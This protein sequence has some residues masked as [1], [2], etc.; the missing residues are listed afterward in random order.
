MNAP[1][2]L[3]F[4]AAALCILLTGCHI[5]SAPEETT[6]AAMDTV[7]SM[8]AYG[9]GAREALNRASEELSRLDRTLSVTGEKSAVSALNSAGGSWTDVGEDCAALLSAATGLSSLTDGALDVTAYP[10]VRAWGFTTGSYRIPDAEELGSLLRKIDWTALELDGTSARLPEGMA[11]DLGAVAK[12]YACDRLAADLREADISS[13]LLDLGQSSILALGAK[14]DGSP[15]RIGLLCP[16]GKNYAGVLELSDRA[17]GTSGDYQR[18]FEQDG[19][20]YCHIM[21]PDT[22]APARSGLRSVTV[23]GPSGLMCDGLSTAF[24]VLGREKSL[25]IR[26]AHPELDIEIIFIDDRGELSLTEGLEDCFFPAETYSDRE[27][28]VLK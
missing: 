15:W 23:V 20:T 24:F 9:D 14:P 4:L 18:F 22:A 25:E 3:R 7:V 16:D 8:T 1:R 19:R 6:V 12:G 17:M 21:D 5:T 28:T 11:L 27:V 26:R 13:A 2:P 10:A